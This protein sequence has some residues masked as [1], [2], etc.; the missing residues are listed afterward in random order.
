MHFL[1]VTHHEGHVVVNHDSLENRHWNDLHEIIGSFVLLRAF[2]LEC[3]LKTTLASPDFLH[4]SLSEIRHR[5]PVFDE[6]CK[7]VARDQMPLV[8]V[9]YIE[10]SLELIV[11]GH[12]SHVAIPVKVVHRVH[13]GLIE[14]LELCKGYGTRVLLSV[15]IYPV[16]VLFIQRKFIVQLL[17]YIFDDLVYSGIVVLSP[18]QRDLLLGALFLAEEFLADI[19]SDLGLLAWLL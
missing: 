11:C 14:V 1:F 3:N 10:D 8:R 12:L 2:G 18:R 7:L 5:V 9:N 13:M 6:V 17:Q 15:E 16:G 19:I 4:Q